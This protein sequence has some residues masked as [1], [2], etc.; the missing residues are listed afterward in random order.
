[1]YRSLSF[2]MAATDSAPR[3]PAWKRIGLKLKYAKDSPVQESQDTRTTK[4]D[5]AFNAKPEP[6]KSQNK[7]SFSDEAPE[8]PAKRPKPAHERPDPNEA[9]RR[10]RAHLAQSEGSER[11]S[12]PAPTGVFRAPNQTP[13]R[14]VFGD[15]E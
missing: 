9:F 13:K 8:T 2:A 11:S 3:V 1:M 12:L 6:V 5:E 14:I 4:S 7:R 15:D 10:N